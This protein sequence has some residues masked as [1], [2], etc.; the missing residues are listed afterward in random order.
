[1]LL[2]WYNT[3][4]NDD[5]S[6]LVGTVWSKNEVSDMLQA[7]GAVAL[8]GAVGDG[9]TDDLTAFENAIAAATPGGGLICEPN[10][11]F[12]VT[13]TLFLSEGVTLDLNG[14][15]L[16]F[17]LSGDKLGLQ[18]MNRSACVNGTVEIQISGLGAT[19]GNYGTPI[20]V[21]EYDGPNGYS[22]VRLQRLSLITDR[23]DGGAGILVTNSSHDVL[24]EDIHFPASST[25]C[26]GIV[27]HWAQD[28]SVSPPA[29]HH[30]YNV[31]IRRVTAE[32]QTNSTNG[33]ALIYFS[34]ASNCSAAQVRAARIAFQYVGFIT[35]GD[36]GVLEGSAA[37]QVAALSGLQFADMVCTDC[38]KTGIHVD[39]DA[40][41]G[42]PRTRY[43]VQAVVERCRMHG[44]ATAS[45]VGF[46]AVG[47]FGVLFEDCQADAFATGLR[48]WAEARRITIRRG[49]FFNNQRDGIEI[50]DSSGIVEDCLVDGA[51]CYGNGIAATASH[52][53]G[54]YVHDALRT[55]IRRTVLG[56]WTP[57]S[58]TTQSFGVL[59][60]TGAVQST[61]VENY[62]RSVKSG[63][64][65]YVLSTAGANYDTVWV[66]NGNRAASGIT[67]RAGITTIPIERQENGSGKIRTIAT[68]LTGAAPADG[69]WELGDVVYREDPA[70][71]GFIGFVCTTA[72]SPGT[73]KTW[74]VIS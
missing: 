31:T 42:S 30:P 52:V 13:D 44:S 47:G 16:R 32:D 12:K 8:Y 58:E 62:V 53:N 43:P 69:A 55:T 7:F 19:G 35:A 34:G 73:W 61:I 41:N 68:T 28:S 74:G 67:F 15:T 25:L 71:G 27:C 4:L 33:F 57:A 60:F 2:D 36:F 50:G 65:A 37:E 38:D 20:V 64:T 22:Q 5:G 23:D 17:V 14:S 11:T 18:P 45:S 63:G 24:I 72:G 39:G 66:F 70:S 10:K 51:E 59:N 49:I 26:S 48:V 54:I 9:T 1:M 21:G 3:L 56:H 46:E 29:T 6:N 40:D